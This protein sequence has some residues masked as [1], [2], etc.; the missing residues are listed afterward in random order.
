MAVDLDGAVVV[1]GAGQGIGFAVAQAFASA[2]RLV[3][4]SDIRDKAADDAA[5]TLQAAGGRAIAFACDVADEP[6]IQVL[7]AFAVE[8]GGSIGVWVNNAGVTRPAML[9]KME[10]AD[11]EWVLRVH[12]VGTFLGIREAARRMIEAG[13]GGSIINVTSIAGLQGTIGQINYAAA[14]GAI[15]AMTKSAAR[16]LAKHKIRVNAVAPLAATPMTAAI[17]TDAK[18]AERYTASIPLGR[19]A[20]P[21]EVASMFTYLASPAASY[22]TGQVMCIDGGMYM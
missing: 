11:F 13:N 2:G 6:R 9:H 20:E 3:V 22:V 8:A 1:T 10:L 4:V 14:K 12:T 15:A 18:L 19:F 16:E 21:E 17:R 5:A 7:G